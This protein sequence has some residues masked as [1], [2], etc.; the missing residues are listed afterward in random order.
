[1][2]TYIYSCDPCRT[3]IEVLKSVVHYDSKE[4]CVVCKLEMRRVPVSPAFVLKGGG[5]ASTGYEKERITFHKKDGSKETV[6]VPNRDLLKG[7]T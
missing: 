3:H 5:W 7:K 2:A 1:V 4:T 6:V